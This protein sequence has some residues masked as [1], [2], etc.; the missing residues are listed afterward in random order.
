[1]RTATTI[2]MS[3]YR[4]IQEEKSM[5]WEVTVSV[6]VRNIFSYE[7]VSNSEWLSR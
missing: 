4:A 3:V 2:V 1:M 5:F 6:I 7:R